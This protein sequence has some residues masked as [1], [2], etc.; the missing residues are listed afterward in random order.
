MVGGGGGGGG[1]VRCSLTAKLSKFLGFKLGGFTS[2]LKTYM[3]Q[4]YQIVSRFRNILVG[5]I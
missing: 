4:K 1:G 5:S 2:Y 3:H